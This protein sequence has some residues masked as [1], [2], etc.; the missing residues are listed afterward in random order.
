MTKLWQ[1]SI[2]ELKDGYKA[3]HK[4][5]YPSDL[6]MVYSNVTGR[7]SR[8]VGEDFLISMMW[9]FLAKRY[10]I[11]YW[12]E[13]FFEA[14]PKV[15]VPAYKRRL[16]YYLGKDS[17]PINHFYE[18]HELGYLPLHMKAIPEGMKV[19][20]RVPTMT[21]R[22]THKRFGWLTNDQE[23]LISFATWLG[24]TSAT[25]AFGYLKRF[26]DAE[27]RT[28]TSVGFS[29]FQAH[30]FSMRGMEGEWG[31]I[32]SAMAHLMV[33]NLGTD[34]FAAISALEHYYGANVETEL[35]GCSVPATEHSVM[36]MG[37]KEGELETFRRLITRVYPKGIVSIVSDTWDFWTVLSKYLPELRSAIISREGKV[38]IRPDSG[39]PVKIICGDPESNDG[40]AIMGAVRLLWYVFG[41]TVNAKGFKELDPHIG[42]IY[43]DSITPDRQREIIAKLEA[44]GFASTN[45]VLGVGS[46]T[47]QYVTRDTKGLAIKATFGVTERGEQAISKDPKTDSG[48][49]KSASG[50]LRV[51]DVDG[52]LVLRENV[53]CEEESG[54]VLQDIFV[55]G[56]LFN[57]TTVTDIRARV[58]MYF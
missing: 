7:G 26:K 15:V 50:L 1:P 46:Y 22:N 41:G 18:L 52:E 55:D 56:K 29:S 28:S 31:A 44:L 16:D 49:K 5:Q 14:D 19:P 58:A 39:D 2:L 21:I 43:G 10:F 42:L 45:V 51:D 17:V 54:G 13:H 27:T 57:P 37:M 35:I 30:D 6:E 9:Q 3:D 25:T 48:L 20:M 4:S 53:S 8:I 40:R 12:G 11:E 24:L 47:Y 36:C 32:M 33:G 34:S 38:V 23:T